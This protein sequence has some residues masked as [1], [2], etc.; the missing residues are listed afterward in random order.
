MEKCIYLYSLIIYLL[1]LLIDISK[2]Y[3]YFHS[4]K[5]YS[6]FIFSR[7]FSEL[8]ISIFPLPLCLKIFDSFLLEG[9]KVFIFLFFILDIISIW[10]SFIREII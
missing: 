8:F 9:Y 4:L 7:I 2:I 5:D 1:L 3:K 6:P 10:N